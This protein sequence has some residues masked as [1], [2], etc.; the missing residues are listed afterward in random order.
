MKVIQLRD[1]GIYIRHE[2]RN[3]TFLFEGHLVKER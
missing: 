1:L 2:S 3:S